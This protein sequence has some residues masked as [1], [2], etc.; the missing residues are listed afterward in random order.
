MNGLDGSPAQRYTNKRLE[1]Q[2]GGSQYEE[3]A[4]LNTEVGAEKSDYTFSPICSPISYFRLP[5]SLLVLWHGL[6]QISTEK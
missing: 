4:H 5:S 1:E 2:G 6:L 3:L